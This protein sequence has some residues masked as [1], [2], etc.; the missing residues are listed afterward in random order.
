[1]FIKTTALK[2]RMV[3]LNKTIS[4]ETRV[5][6]HRPFLATGS[7]TWSTGIVEVALW[8]RRYD[9]EDKGQQG[10]NLHWVHCGIKD[11]DGEVDQGG[12]Q[13]R[14]PVLMDMTL[15]APSLCG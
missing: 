13:P 7:K 11:G 10:R 9:L 1:V 2:D 12:I 5:H 6:R 15:T 4:L 14:T 3:E 8:E